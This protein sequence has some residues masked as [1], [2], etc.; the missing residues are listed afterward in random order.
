MN[1]WKIEFFIGND[2]S[3]HVIGPTSKIVG[4]LVSSNGKMAHIWFCEIFE[5]HHQFE[6]VP[7]IK[8][9]VI[10]SMHTIFM[11]CYSV[12]VWCKY[13]IKSENYFL[14]FLSSRVFYMYVA[15]FKLK[16]IQ[17]LQIFTNPENWKQGAIFVGLLNNQWCTYISSLQILGRVSGH[18]GRPLQSLCFSRR[19]QKKKKTRWPP[20]SPWPLIGWNIR[21]FSSKT[22]ERNSAKLNR[23]QQGFFK[24]VLWAEFRPQSRWKK[25]PVF[26][27]KVDEISQSKAP[28]TFSN[29]SFLIQ[30]CLENSKMTISSL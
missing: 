6:S 12:H 15:L 17:N 23:K 14:F 22:T 3:S 21:D 7:E 8:E 25:L 29:F 10:C 24:A 11:K 28:Q 19:S 20:L 9:W 27:Q 26:S 13:R 1:G 4:W 30:E 16:A 18:A 5:N 2:D